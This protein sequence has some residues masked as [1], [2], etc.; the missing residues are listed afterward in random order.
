MKN[1]ADFVDKISNLEV[2]PPWKLVSFD[3]TALFTSIPIAKAIE[4]VKLR[5]DTDTSWKKDTTLEANDI[6]QLL[7]ICLNT[8]YFSYNNIIYR[9]KQGAAMGSPISPIIAN[10]FMEDYEQLAIKTAK[11]PPKLLYR[12][13]DDTFTMLLMYEMILLPITSIASINT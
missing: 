8:T 1:S 7:D 2:P 11:F 10:L 12:Y 6:V 3:V 9:Q 4:V 5:L 13:V